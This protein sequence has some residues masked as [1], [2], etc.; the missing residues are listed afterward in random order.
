MLSHTVCNILL[1]IQDSFVSGWMHFFFTQPQ[2]ETLIYK[3]LTYMT[4]FS[5]LFWTTL[6]QHLWLLWVLFGHEWR[7][8][9]S[10]EYPPSP[11][12]PRINSRQVVYRILII[13]EKSHVNPPQSGANSRQELNCS[14]T[15]NRN[16]MVHCCTITDWAFNDYQALC[17]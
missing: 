9:H 2:S 6:L 1:W 15:F 14:Q 11:S 16:Q 7:P 12:K 5:R 17:A 8:G 10:L 13:G 4:C 3:I